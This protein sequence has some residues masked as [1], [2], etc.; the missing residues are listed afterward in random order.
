MAVN[1]KTFYCVFICNAVFWQTLVVNAASLLD[2]YT[3]NYILGHLADS[4][5]LPMCNDDVMVSSVGD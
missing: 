5:F 1:G 2:L 3:S 4:F